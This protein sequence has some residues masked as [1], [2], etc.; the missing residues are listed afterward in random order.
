MIKG[1][2]YEL[3]SSTQQ[4]VELSINNNQ[5]LIK[6][7]DTILF[8]GDISNVEISSRIG[9]IQRKITF[10][11]NRVFTTKENDLIDLYFLKPL[12]KKSLIHK[13]ESNL[14]LILISL[15]FTTLVGFSFLK[16]G[17]PYS[18]E[19]LA[20]LLPP[21]LNTEI[22]KTTFETMDKHIFSPTKLSKDKKQKILESYTKNVLPFIEEDSSSNI[23]INFRDWKIGK[24]AIANAIALPDGNII[25]TDE[26]INISKNNEEI[27]SV[28]FHEVGHI[29]KR[30]SL[31]KI[32]EG[33]FLSFFIMYISGDATMFSDLGVGISSLLID[34]HY[35]RDHELDADKYALDKMLKS[36]I[37]PN[38][39][40][41]I[42][43]RISNNEDEKE[44]ILNYFSSHP[45]NKERTNLT[46]KYLECF[47]IGLIKCK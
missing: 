16:W 22:S 46:N 29:I 31:Q 20:F 34:T 10:E 26:F 42:L 18:S 4:S 40:S 28:V 24:K 38:H 41:N 47:K 35:S 5:Y 37:N 8:S 6:T 43:Y 19:K 33:T 3:D 21:D 12:K 39:L 2:L 15:I 7:N 27:N 36:K 1:N 44:S 17:I 13:L 30:H 9:N 32:I 14:I 45:T 25:L 23:K 11:N